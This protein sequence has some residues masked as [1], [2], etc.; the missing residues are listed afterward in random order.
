MS[1][2]VI[3]LES[4]STPLRLKAEPMFSQEAL[5]RAYS[6]GLN[7]GLTRRDD[8]QTRNLRAALERLT[9]ALRE[10]E[11]RRAALRGE[12][13]AALAPLLSEILDALTPSIVSQRLE[14]VLV[15]EMH[16]LVAQTSPVR[17]RIAC[18]NKLRDMV[19]RCL[20]E[21]GATG[22]ELEHSASDCISLTLQ[23]GRIEF[24]QEQVSEQIRAL[25]NEIRQDE[26]KWTH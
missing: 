8:E 10:D 13:I 2:A 24:S 4:F 1:T 3:K 26:P 12:A 21:T 7:E 25:V 9:E 6:E 18:S 19:E 14:R 20:T 16:R 15:D 11:A 5:D 22:V 23:G 17:A